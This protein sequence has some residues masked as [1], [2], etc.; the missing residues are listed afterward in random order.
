MRRR[1]GLEGVFICS[2]MRIGS[3]NSVCQENGAMREAD[4]MRHMANSVHLVDLLWGCP[5]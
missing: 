3:V 1:P 4:G 2:L 5:S